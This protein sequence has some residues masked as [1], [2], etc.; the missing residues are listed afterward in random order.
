MNGSMGIDYGNPKRDGSTSSLTHGFGGWP[1]LNTATKR[2]RTALSTFSKNVSTL[3]PTASV[4]TRQSTSS[5]L[6]IPAG[7]PI[8][9]RQ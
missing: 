6:L 3:A 5:C 2:F 9:G 8:S 7:L 1:D 4:L